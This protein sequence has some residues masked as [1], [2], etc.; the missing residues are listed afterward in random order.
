MGIVLTLA[1]CGTYVPEIQE[2]PWSHDVAALIQAIAYSIHCELRNSVVDVKY[3]DL[4]FDSKM[5][6]S[7][8]AGSMIGEHRSL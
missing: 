1:G 2:N 7:L 3:E 5:D 4:K 6:A 8:R